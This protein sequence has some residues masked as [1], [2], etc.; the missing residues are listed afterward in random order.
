MPT[1]VTRGVASARGAGTFS[2]A[3]P[4][5]PPPPPGPTPP[6]PPPPGPPPVGQS[7]FFGSSGSWTAPSGVTQISSLVIA[8]GNFVQTPE[9]WVY[10]SSL[11]G[12]VLSRQSG[13]PIQPGDDPVTYTYAQAGS[14]ADAQ[15]AS[16][17]SGGSGP[18]DVN[19]TNLDLVAFPSSPPQYWSSIGGFGPTRVRGVLTATSGPWDNRSGQ[20][21]NGLQPA[22][23]WY[24]GGE[25]F[26]PAVTT[27]G[28]PSSAFG[29]TVQGGTQ[30]N[31][32]PTQSFGTVSVNPGQT[33]AINVG[34]PEGGYV[35]FQFVQG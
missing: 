26:F 31:P 16:Y 14:F 7:V 23:F 34:G 28:D 9:E 25:T 3:P 35:Q 30:G 1:I 17:N 12:V 19:F 2:A 27:N 29:Y 33:Y 22:V 20:I 18:R 4:P 6:P 11:F 32:A 5:P 24:I 21:A 13:T 8:G 15:L 10:F